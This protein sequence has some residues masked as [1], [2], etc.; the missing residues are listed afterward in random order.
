MLD[1]V[2]IWDLSTSV[3]VSKCLHSMGENFPLPV[4]FIHNGAAV[5]SGNMTGSVAFWDIENG[6]LINTLSHT[7]EFERWSLFFQVRFKYI[8]Y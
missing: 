2:D 3:K 7:G 1:G 8:N 6:H 5:I 4:K